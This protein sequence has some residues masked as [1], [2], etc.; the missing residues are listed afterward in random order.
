MPRDNTQYIHHISSARGTR[1]QDLTKNRFHIFS[2]Y[3]PQIEFF[4]KSHVLVP[5]IQVLRLNQAVKASGHKAGHKRGTRLRPETR[6]YLREGISRKSGSR[7]EG[8]GRGERF[9]GARNPAPP[10]Q[11]RFSHPTPVLPYSFPERSP[12]VLLYR[13]PWKVFHTFP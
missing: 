12:A 5:R 13:A 10:T 2:F 7:H 8:R 1:A 6:A 11:G 3:F 9:R 4:L